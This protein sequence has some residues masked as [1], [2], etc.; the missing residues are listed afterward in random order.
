MAQNQA[1]I[2]G[3]LI[4]RLFA[5]AISVGAASTLANMD[6]VSIG[7]WP[8]LGEWQQ[9]SILVVAMTATVL[10]WDGYLMSIEDRPLVGFWRFAIDIG[11]VF[12]Y[13]FL[14]MTS[15]HLTWW[16]NIHA[17]TYLM[18][19]AWDVLSIRE[20]L[21]KYYSKD[22]PLALT[23]GQNIFGVYIGGFLGSQGVSRGP[24]ITLCWAVFF[25]GLAYISRDGLSERIFL[26]SI[27]ALAG[28]VLY[29]RDKKNRYNM[30]SRA[31]LILSLLA[32]G[33]I[34]AR[35]G[36]S[37]GITDQAVVDLLHRYI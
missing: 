15:S 5:V 36:A 29:R 8:D 21:Y 32:I 30:L 26:T 3:D 24:I 17:I 16:L 2:R 7:R 4:R 33:A 23:A 22:G 34:Y 20:Y 25:C 9:L 6:W 35:L 11:L 13:M 1:A 19:L 18:Y 14:L 12:I 10:S 27:L 37:A 28:L 31:A